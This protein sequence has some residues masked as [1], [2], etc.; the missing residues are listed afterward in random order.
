MIKEMI[1]T[2]SDALLVEDLKPYQSIELLIENHPIMLLKTNTGLYAYLNRCPHQAKRLSDSQQLH[3]DE[4]SSLIECE[5]HG[6][7]F[8]PTTGL[9]VA[10]PCQGKHLQM[11]DVLRSKQQYKL[12]PKAPKKS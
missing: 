6:A 8:L 7:Q 9:C 2:S 3:L 5:Q 12:A 10:G 4:S 11:F 1:L